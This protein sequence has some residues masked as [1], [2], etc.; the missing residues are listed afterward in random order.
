MNKELIVSF[1]QFWDRFF[2]DE[3]NNV[4]FFKELL[5]GITKNIIV[6]DDPEKSHIIINNCHSNIKS[7]NAVH[8]S[9]IGESIDCPENADIVLGGFDEKK[10][11]N[12]ITMPIFLVFLYCNNYLERCINKAVVQ[13]V[14]TKFCCYIVSN[15]LGKERNTIF[16]LLNSYKKVDSTGLELNN[17][18]Q[19]LTCPWGSYEFYRYISQY[20]FIICGEHGIS[21]F[22]M[23]EKIFH[24]YLGNSIPI[25][26][27]PEYVK[28]LFNQDSFIYLDG[29]SDE[30]FINLVNKVIEI[31]N[32]DSKWL[33]MVNSTPFINN[34][35]PEEL[36]MEGLKKKF[37]DRVSS[38]L[39]NRT[40]IN[41][42]MA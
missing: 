22:C 32:D 39:K 14:P 41:N 13:N 6:Q 24:G 21:E 38:V 10:Y 34:T 9:Y 1:H 37:A 33:S 28:Q 8:V 17:T 3:Q 20:K 18:G 23:S 12:V 16:Y 42:D 25:Y 29:V 15:P 2:E 40:S 27:G 19:L 11:K 31:D 35:L 26:C 36:Q 30:S 7:K 4:S 5:S